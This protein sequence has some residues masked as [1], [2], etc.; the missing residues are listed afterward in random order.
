MNDR[1]SN[2]SPFIVM[3]IIKRTTE[4]ENVIHF[5]VGQPDLPP[6]EK[7]KSALMEIS[8]SLSFP[9]TESLGIAPLREKIAE[10]YKKYY[11]L[12]IPINR[13]LVTPGTSG[14]FLIAYAITLNSG[15]KIALSDPSYPC[16]K[17][18]SY[19]L[20][21]VP[22]FIPVDS[23]TNYEMRVEHIKEL[24]DIKTVQISSP[25][26]PIGNIYGNQALKE[27]VEYC[28]NKGI[29]FISDEIYHGLT[30]TGERVSS[31]LEFSDNVIVINGF[32]KYFCMP[33]IRLGWMIMPDNLVR[34]AEILMQNLFISASSVSQQIG[35]YAFDYEHLERCR[36]MFKERRDFLYKELSEIFKVDVVPEGAFYI[37]VDVS[38]YTDNSFEFAKELLENI[39]VAV[40]PGVD[41]GKYNTHKYLRFAYTRNIDHMK[42][43]IE[44]IKSYLKSKK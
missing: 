1:L 4:L 5:E 2:V 22:E 10:F 20:D 16:Y 35:L 42:E 26:N 29:N 43:G 19:M 7:V 37:W 41:F 12:D 27:L 34:K 13:I 15:E 21:I 18:F 9:Y 28:D 31:A 38:K 39:Q 8:N 33:G 24:K 30:Y 40:T 25:S 17:N 32:S 44:R 23:S 3:D 14:A 36:D 11:N 6:T